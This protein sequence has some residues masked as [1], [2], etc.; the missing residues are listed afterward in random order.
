MYPTYN[1][2]DVSIHFWLEEYFEFIFFTIGYLV[3]QLPLPPAVIETLLFRAF[4]IA[5]LSGNALNS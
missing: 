1:E 4:N 5:A 3:I 2:Q